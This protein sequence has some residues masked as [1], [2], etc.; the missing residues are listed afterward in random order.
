MHKQRDYFV[1]D[2]SFDS[3]E[4]NSISCTVWVEPRQFVAPRSRNEDETKQE[5]AMRI[6]VELGR[7]RKRPTFVG[8]LH[9]LCVWRCAM[10]FCVVP[11][12][13]P[14]Q[15]ISGARLL[16]FSFR[17]ATPFSALVVVHQK[18]SCSS[19]SQITSRQVM[20][21]S[22]ELFYVVFL[23]VCRHIQMPS[24]NDYVRGT[25]ATTKWEL[26]MSKLNTRLY[27]FQENSVELFLTCALLSLQ[28]T[29]RLDGK[30]WSYLWRRVS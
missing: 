19:L 18:Q 2:W 23:C 21:Y 9:Y 15:N 29:K 8:S 24:S 4:I 7:Q 3:V 26:I 28:V 22:R 25:R 11:S 30:A 20:N 5:V 17:S 1:K 16:C 10:A 14:H 12:L 6:N 27:K 13:S